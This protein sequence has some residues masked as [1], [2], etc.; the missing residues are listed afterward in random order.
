MTADPATPIPSTDATS[1][2]P[3]L[4][5]LDP[6]ELRT[7]RNVRTDLRL[8]TEFVDSIATLDTAQSTHHSER[9]RQNNNFVGGFQQRL[10]QNKRQ[11]G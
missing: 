7:V 10:R 6:A 3:H 9:N 8:T 11:Y 1:T 2:S 4:V 5:H